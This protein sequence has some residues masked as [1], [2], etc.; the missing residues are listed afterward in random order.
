MS[1]PHLAPH[2]ACTVAGAAACYGCKDRVIQFIG[3]KHCVL[4][5]EAA[6]VRQEGI[7]YLVSSLVTPDIGT[8]SA[9][10]ERKAKTSVDHGDSV[11]AVV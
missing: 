1:L 3:G 11:L 6:C 4:C 5:T 9:F 2:K 10:M 8:V 7:R